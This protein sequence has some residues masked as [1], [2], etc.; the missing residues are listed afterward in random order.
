MTSC[1]KIH[2][3]LVGSLWNA[4]HFGCYVLLL[5]TGFECHC[6]AGQVDG[7]GPP[8]TAATGFVLA[9]VGQP[10]PGLLVPREGDQRRELRRRSAGGQ[11]P[12]NGRPLRPS[13]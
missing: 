11:L 10:Q 1:E 2:T 6:T 9:A 4:G 5:I 3:G 7:R 8:S 12:Q 13:Q